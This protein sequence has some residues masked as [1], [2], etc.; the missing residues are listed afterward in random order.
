MSQSTVAESSISTRQQA[1]C[2]AFHAFGRRWIC[3]DD[4]AV[5]MLASSL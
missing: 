3:D 2:G 5:L 1:P 4:S